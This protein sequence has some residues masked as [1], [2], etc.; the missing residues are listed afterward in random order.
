MSS[1]NRSNLISQMAEAAGITKAQA[2]A[3][4]N[5]TLEGIKGSLTD[6]KKVTLVGFGT[7]DVSERAARSGRDPRTKAPIQIAASKN[8]RFKAGKNLK[9]SVN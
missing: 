9:S 3:A 2:D 8:V 1:V 6:G 7:F 4:L 5:A